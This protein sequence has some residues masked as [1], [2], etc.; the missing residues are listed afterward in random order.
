M[1]HLQL[2][3]IGISIC[4]KP[5]GLTS[6]ETNKRPPCPAGKWENSCICHCLGTGYIR[7][8]QDSNFC[9]RCF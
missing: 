8:E 3:I 1:T 4:E 5:N 9:I 6:S 2:A 7:N